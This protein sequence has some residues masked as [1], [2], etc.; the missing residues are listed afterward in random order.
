MIDDGEDITMCE[1]LMVAEESPHYSELA[2]LAFDLASKSNALA[3]S[4]PEAMQT[5]LASTVRTMNCYYSNLIEGHDTHPISADR[6]MRGDLSADPEERNLQL[7]AVAHISVQKWIDEGGLT[8]HPVSPESIREIHQRFCADLPPELLVVANPETG[9]SIEV[10]G[11][12]YR[13]HH[14]AVGQHVPVSPGAV[15]RFMTHLHKRYNVA[16]KVTAVLSA[17]YAHH[18]IAWV[19]PFIDMNGR[20]VRMVSHAMLQDSVRSQGLWSVSRGLARQVDQYKLQMA[21]ADEQRRGDRDGR[22]NLSE[23]RLAGF[24]RFFLKV[25]IDQVEFMSGLMKPKELQDRVMAWTLRE[26]ADRKLPKSADI[27]MRLTFASGEV[28]RKEVEKV[29]GIT[30]RGARKITKALVDAG[31]LISDSPRAPLR[32]NFSPKLAHEWMPGLFPAE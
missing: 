25:S 15:P 2:D 27:V 11:G 23:E 20:V 24:A 12:E 5:S 1:P 9:A 22:G 13:E 30:D 7:E 21:R 29:L 10:V 28:E 18:R 19:H 3:S 4:L 8:T 16:G 26:M 31:A 17:A 14:V 32:L 6:A